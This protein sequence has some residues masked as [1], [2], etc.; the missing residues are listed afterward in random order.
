M[1]TYNAYTAEQ[2]DFLRDN[3][4]RMSRGELTDSFN[5]QF[6]T[7]KTAMAIKAYCNKHGWYS[8][9]DGRFKVGC[10]SWQTGITG[11]DF[12]SHYTDE[13]FAKMT[14][15]LIESNKKWR[16]GDE[17]IRHGVPMII[18]SEDYTIRYDKRMIFK[19]RY[20]WEHAHGKIPPGHRIIHLDGDV[21]NCNLDNLYCVPDKF[22]PTL[23]KNHWLTDDRDHTLT[24]VMLCELNQVIKDVKGV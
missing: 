24:A 6:G 7:N 14:N 5:A 9:D 23:N 10:R 2:Q 11:D 22:I 13:S 17:V 4:K 12:K 8:G 20:V 3:C 16:I 19:R 15:K 18:I 21:M 1:G